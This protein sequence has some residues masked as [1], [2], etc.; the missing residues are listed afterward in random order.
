MSVIN[1]TKELL[2]SIPLYREIHIY[3]DEKKRFLQ[4]AKNKFANGNVLGSYKDY[5]NAFKKHRV[6]YSE[7]MFSYEYWHLN[8]EERNKFISTSEMQ[9]LYRKLGNKKVREVFHDKVLFLKA[10]SPFVHRWWSLAESLSLEDLKKHAEQFD[11]IAKPIDGT[12]GNGIF[13]IIS[14]KVT[15]WA[16]LYEHLNK[17]KYLLEQ[18]IESC[19]ELN[20]FHPTSLN[21][22]RVVTISSRNHCKVFGAILRMGAHGSIIDN[23]HA[24]GIYAPINIVTGQI[25]V[26]AIDAH[27]NHYDT[28]PDTGKPIKGFRIP[29]WDKIISTCKEASQEIPNI[30]FAGW[31][32]CINSAGQIE[33]VEG[34]HAPDF[35]G[36]MQAPLKKGVKKEIQQVVL[37]IMGV[38]PL[39]LISIWNY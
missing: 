16:Q 17:N 14:A 21:T 23:T 6:T 9:I 12:R 22:I 32:I 24:G 36:G 7:Y 3:F 34:N 2:W 35:D 8:E 29:E 1:K 19:N 25:D 31:D 13:K 33:I 28:H 10:F 18:C 15:D 38:D 37:D 4:E 30:H 26:P 39:K 20:E 5:V 11:I 27:N